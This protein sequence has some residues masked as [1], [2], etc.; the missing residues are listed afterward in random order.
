MPQLCAIFGIDGNPRQTEHIQNI[1][2]A[3]L[4]A[5]REGDHIEFRH[6]IL[7]LQ[8][9]QGQQ[10]L[11]H[12]R[13]HIPPGGENAFAPDTRHLVHHAIENPHAQVGHAQFIGIR[14]AERHPDIHLILLFDDLMYSPPVYRA[15]FAHRQDTAKCICHSLQPRFHPLHCTGK[16]ANLQ[17]E[18][19]RFRLPCP[20]HRIFWERQ[21]YKSGACV[22]Q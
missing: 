16:P 22:G 13:L 3:H 8:R 4:I 18:I 15:V 11:P 7:A 2:V 6:R 1:G 5:H 9:P 14:K 19:S 20:S 12:R 17:E 21:W 10:L